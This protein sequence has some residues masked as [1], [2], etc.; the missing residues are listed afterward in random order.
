MR[1][2]VRILEASIAAMLLLGSLAFIS[3]Y[4]SAN[5][6]PDLD[7]ILLGLAADGRL[8]A[9][10]AA[11][12][13]AGLEAEVQVPGFSHAVQV[14]DRNNCTGQIP[15]ARSVF[16]ATYL[17]AGQEGYAPTAVKLYAYR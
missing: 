11:N 14:C 2:F 3:G 5:A 15:Q 10:A 7:A 4:R 8:Q 6:A 1:G 17:T 9:Y 16:V 12:D 13:Q